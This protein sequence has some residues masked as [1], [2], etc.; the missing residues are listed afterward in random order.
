MVD[1]IYTDGD[2]KQVKRDGIQLAYFL[3]VLMTIMVMKTRKTTL[4]ISSVILQQN[5]RYVVMPDLSWMEKPIIGGET[6]I[7]SVNIDLSCKAFFVLDMF[8]T[9]FMYLR[10]TIMSQ[11]WSQM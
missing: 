5:L 11:S 1:N 4:K 9:F 8:H 6:T 2:D 3:G 10:Q 7:R